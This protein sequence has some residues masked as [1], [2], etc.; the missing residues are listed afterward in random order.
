MI[1]ASDLD[2]TLIYSENFLKKHYAADWE[3]HRDKF[4]ALIE[5]YQGKPLSYIRKEIIMA[6]VSMNENDSFIPVTTRTEEQY[7]RIE[8]VKLGITPKYAITTNGAKILYNGEVDEDWSQRVGEILD[9]LK[10]TPLDISELASKI[11]PEEVI[12]KNRIAEDVFCYLVVDRDK[13]TEE[14]R[15][16]LNQIFDA[17]NWDLSLQG[18]KLYF[19]PRAISKGAAL[20]YV[21]AKLGKDIQ[22]AA[23]DSLL[24]ISFL[25][26]AK[27]GIIPQHGEIF[28]QKQNGDCDFH[29]CQ[30]FGTQ[31]SC[32]VL[33]LVNSLLGR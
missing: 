16:K 32:D 26:K 28:R 18:T 10:Y 27:H 9:S 25:K 6:L 29:I 30:N 21:A 14:H 19:M 4:M 17:S 33:E 23:G 20:L 22:V 11:L 31:A 13:F 3:V 12:K 5:Y 1:F 24:D 7:K 8:F 2:Q 15:A